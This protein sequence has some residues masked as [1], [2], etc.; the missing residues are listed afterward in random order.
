ML[1]VRSRGD[2]WFEIQPV[3]GRA[4]LKVSRLR[5]SQLPETIFRSIARLS[6]AGIGNPVVGHG[7][8]VGPAEWEL[9]DACLF[10]GARQGDA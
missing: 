2:D 4:Y 7:V 3:V 1:I 10:R 9:E 6:L 5:T 8:K